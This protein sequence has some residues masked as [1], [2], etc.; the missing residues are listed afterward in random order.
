MRR[1]PKQ[2][3]LHYWLS[4]LPHFPVLK[5]KLCYNCHHYFQF[6]WGW[7]WTKDWGHGYFLYFLCKNCAATRQEAIDV[8]GWQKT[9]EC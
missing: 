8:L 6:E 2:K 4:L 5:A 1:K 7:K 3:K 9:G